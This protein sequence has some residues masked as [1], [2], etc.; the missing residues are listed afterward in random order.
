METADRRMMQLFDR[1][2]A[3]VVGGKHPDQ[4]NVAV[5]DAFRLGEYG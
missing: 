3:R 2:R 1:V 5:H 4:F